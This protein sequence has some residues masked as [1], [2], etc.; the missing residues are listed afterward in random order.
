MICDTE[1]RAFWGHFMVGGVYY[2]P[3]L[4]LP[5]TVTEI[6]RNPNLYITTIVRAD[7]D[8]PCYGQS[9]SSFPYS[10]WHE[11]DYPMLWEPEE[12]ETL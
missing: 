11:E 5:F 1:Q 12:A 4:E 3:D 8:H 2:D 6:R 9:E 7:L 10:I